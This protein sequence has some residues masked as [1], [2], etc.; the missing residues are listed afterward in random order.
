MFLYC[1]RKKNSNSCIK[2]GCFICIKPLETS[3]TDMNT[4]R[5]VIYA[6]TC[7]MRHYT[8]WVVVVYMTK[9]VVIAKKR[10][11]VL[12][13]ERTT[14]II[15]KITIYIVLLCRSPVGFPFRATAMKIIRLSYV[16]VV[17]WKRIK[18]FVSLG[19]VV[20]T[21][22]ARRRGEIVVSHAR[23]I[24]DSGAVIVI[25]IVIFFFFLN[26]LRRGR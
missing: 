1:T 14:E 20:V 17:A 8:R 18:F 19:R 21:P 11:R 3:S 26:S 4:T 25:N 24:P 22:R 13:T 10:G 6:H 12:L 7:R 5:G 23:R 2:H 9:H 15:S 16:I